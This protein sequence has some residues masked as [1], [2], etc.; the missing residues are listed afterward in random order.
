MIIHADIYDRF[1]D[2]LAVERSRLV[3]S[4]DPKQRDTFIGPMISVEGEAQRLKRWIDDAVA[5]ARRCC[6]AAG[7]RAICSR[8]RC[9]RMCPRGAMSSSRKRSGQSSCCR[10]SPR[11]RSRAGRGQRQQV[12]LA[13]GD[14]FTSD[15]SKGARRV[16]SSRRRRHRAS[17]MCRASA[18]TTCPMAGS[19]TRAGAR[20]GPLC[21]GGYDRDPESGDP[22]DL[23]PYTSSLR[24]KRSNPE[25]FT[26]LWIAASLR[27]SQ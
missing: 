8:R 27:S 23:A 11:F 14:L 6:A 1:R 24:A 12:R 26:L 18:S 2:M 25:R 4:G 7:A 9:S 13:S 21:D 5:A 22:A 19:R 10:S 20:R 15:C 16:G 3:K 17:T